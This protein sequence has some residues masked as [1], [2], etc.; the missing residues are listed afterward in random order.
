MSIHPSVILSERAK[1]SADAEIGPYCVIDGEVEIGPGTVVESHAR[2]GSRYGRVTIG[3]NNRIQHGAVLGGPPQDLGYEGGAYTALDDRLAQSHR[4]VRQ[5]QRRHGE[6]RRRHARRQSQLHH[7]VHA[8]RPRLPTRRSRH[9]RQRRA[10]RGP[11]D[12]SSITRYVSGLTG[13]TQFTRLGAYSFMAAGAFANKDIVPFTIAEGHW[14]TPRAINRV[15]LE[16]RRLRRRRAAQH[17]QRDSARARPRA[18][19]RGSHGAHR[20]RVRRRARR[21][22]TCSTSSATPS[23]GSHAGEQAAHGGRRRRLS[24]PV[25]RAEAP[26]ARR[27][28]ARR[29][30][31][32]RRRAQPQRRRRGRHERGCRIIASCS[33]RSTPSRSR[34]RRPS[35]SRWRE[36]F[37]EHGVHV[38][39]EKPMTRTSAEAA[40]PHEARRRA[41]A[42]APSRPRRAV[43]SCA[44]SPRARR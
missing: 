10:V 44:R 31:R 33:A 13:F 3:A 32:P 43:Q 16:A 2:I 28:R 17:R 40:D 1:I 12:R 35:I 5:H 9:H 41:Q 27:R 39:V 19:D 23:A 20:G 30:L 26:R 11:R 36:F 24:R 6:G 29:R 22:S 42:Q 25:S 18:D 21:S 8:H 34:R 4:R 7:G 14:A 15:G 38:L 37:L